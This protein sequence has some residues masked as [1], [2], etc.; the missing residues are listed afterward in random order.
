MV[1][2]V[3]GYLP[4]LHSKRTDTPEVLRL[5]ILIGPT[6]YQPYETAV[7]CGEYLLRL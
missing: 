2:K 6:P 1:D 3:L 7:S 5:A 4:V